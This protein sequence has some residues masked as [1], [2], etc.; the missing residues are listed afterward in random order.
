MATPN[1]SRGRLLTSTWIGAGIGVDGR[2]QLVKGLRVETREA[3]KDYG[4]EENTALRL[5]G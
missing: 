3:G 5:G 1:A 2:P 4:D